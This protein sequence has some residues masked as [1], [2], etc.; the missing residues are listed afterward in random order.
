MSHRAVFLDRDGTI[1]KDVNYCRRPEDFHMLPGAAAAIAIL[2]NRGFKVVV[3]TNQS[4][5]ARGYF[6]EGILE[7]IHEKMRR[8]L[9]ELGAS[10]DAIYYCPHHPNDDCPCRKP[11]IGLFNRAALEMG[12]DLGM[13]Y[14]VGDRETDVL[15]GRAAGCR[16]VSVETG[17]APFPAD[18]VRPDYC[19]PNLCEA[20]EWMISR[21]S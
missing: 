6:A 16:T 13:S 5:I 19:A 15:A 12:L 2:N 17:P 9:T 20:A 4:G 3:V 18:G 8:Q 14:M 7:A 21:D 1:S 10:V 11:K